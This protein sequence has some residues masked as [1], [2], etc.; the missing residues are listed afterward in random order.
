M[1]TTANSLLT[2]K[3]LSILLG[4]SPR[5]IARNEARLGLHQFK[6]SVNA[7]VVFYKGWLVIPYL[8]KKGLVPD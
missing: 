2:R 8:Q 7:R 1:K 5:C 6:A 4:M 3:E